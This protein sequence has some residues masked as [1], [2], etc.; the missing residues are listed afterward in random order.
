MENYISANG[1]PRVIPKGLLVAI[2]GNEDKINDQQILSTILSLVKKQKKHI[3]I[4]TTAS[5]Y[6]EEAGEAYFKAFARDSDHIVGSMHITSREQAAD[7]SLVKRITAADIIFFTGGYQLRIT[8]VLG[9]SPIEKE[10]LRRYEQECCIIAGTSAG[11]SAMSKTMIYGG[12]ER[13]AL[14][15]GTINVT[16]GLGLIDNAI[17]DT[18]FVERGRFSRLMQVVSTNSGNTGIGLGEDAAIIIESG[19]ILRAIGSGVTVILD[20]QY[21]KHTNIAE[22][23]A[24]EAIAIENLVIHTIVNGYGYDLCE[25]KYLKPEDLKWLNPVESEENTH[26]NTGNESDTRPQLL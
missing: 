13:V 15:K 5:R 16:T 21:R 19:C 20:G 26:E 8:S 2:G 10:L 18:H 12:E 1:K 4:I 25:K 6:S 22:I 9:G 23:I 11:A 3:E 24:D 7:I 14:R 17:I